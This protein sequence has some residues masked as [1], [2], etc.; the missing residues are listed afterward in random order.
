MITLGAFK[1]TK[2][3]SINGISV[4]HL[5]SNITLL[6][7]DGIFGSRRSD[8]MPDYSLT[9]VKRPL[10]IWMKIFHTGVCST[11]AMVDNLLLHNTNTTYYILL[12]IKE[13]EVWSKRN[14]NFGNFRY[15]SGNFFLCLTLENIFKWWK[16]KMFLYWPSG[17]KLNC[18]QVPL[19]STRG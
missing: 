10:G 4:V 5:H 15:V 17:W 11:I 3:I 6:K 8:H 12:I 1:G 16:G 9:S 2:P 7:K 14:I 13:I 18:Q 19:M